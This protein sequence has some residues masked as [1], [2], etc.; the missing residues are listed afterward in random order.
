M[1][2]FIRFRTIA[3]QFI[4]IIAIILGLGPL[5]CLFL[6]P[7]DAISLNSFVEEPKRP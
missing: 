6:N 7:Q 5:I 1:L 4:I 2:L 3:S